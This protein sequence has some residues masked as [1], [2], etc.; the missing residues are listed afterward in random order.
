MGDR[1]VGFV[2]GASRGIGR[3]TALGLAKA[4]YD[5]VVTARSADAEAVT[6]DGTVSDDPDKGATLAGGLPALAAELE[7]LGAKCTRLSLDLTD[8]DSV[9]AAATAA[10]S[11]Y[12]RV[13]VFVNNAIYVG[14]GINDFVLE[15]NVD[16]IDRVVK[17]DAITPLILL[18]AVLPGMIERGDG[19]IIHLTSGAATL[20][21]RAPFGKGGWGLAYAIAKGGAH[22]MAGVLHAEFAGN[23]VRAYNLN[24][25]HVLT[26][27]GKAR[28]AR[29]GSQP[30]GQSAEIPAAAAVWLAE[31]NDATRALA[32]RDVV[33][34][35]LVR[36]LQLPIAGA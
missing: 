9:S 15:T 6:F 28:A 33:A 3:A 31:T 14:P 20:A 23:G 25:G 8:R 26:E 2:T 13:D 30:T 19:A 29:A 24:P 27:L 11:A 32:G 5:L 34:L 36:D 18:Q 10:V 17:A 35:D 16:L 1:R 21:P 7:A 22:R 4:G 12:G